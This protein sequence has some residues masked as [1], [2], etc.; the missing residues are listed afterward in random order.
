MTATFRIIPIICLFI[1]LH[2][3]RQFRTLGS[4]F[5]AFI[6]PAAYEPKDAAVRP[7]RTIR[8]AKFVLYFN[9]IL[10]S[11]IVISITYGVFHV[12]YNT[13]EMFK[14][15]DVVRYRFNEGIRHFQDRPSEAL[16]CFS[17]A[18]KTYLALPEY[19]RDL[20]DNQYQAALCRC[21]IGALEM[22]FGRRGPAKVSLDQ[23]VEI[24]ER[25]SRGPKSQMYS[26]ELANMRIRYAYI[27]ALGT[28]LTRPDT[29]RIGELADKN[30]QLLQQMPVTDEDTTCR[31]WL[32]LAESYAL[33]G[34]IEEGRRWYDK[35]VEW[36]EAHHIEDGELIRLR[37]EA[38]EL[39]SGNR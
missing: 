31:G 18:L 1:S 8:A 10:S 30:I 34:D 39:L 11:S 17:E 4:T 19:D 29:A 15:S 23:A 21:N 33:K 28:D 20:A 13:K 7:R 22:H 24:L 3:A 32:Y 35:S 12:M 14:R 5:E 38:A 36:I 2:F 25:L 16:K 6:G 27:L 37:A 9:I 26:F